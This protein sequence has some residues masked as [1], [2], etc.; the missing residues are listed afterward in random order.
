MIIVHGSVT[1]PQARLSEALQLSQQHV[2]RSRAE[3]GCIEHGV[4]QDPEIAGRLVFVEKWA[5]EAALKQHFA[6]PASIA[7]VDEISA[8]A[9]EPP[10]ISLFYADEISI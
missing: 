6:V 4:Y 5:D 2:A 1:V 8:L 9:T 10:S 3:S 7:F